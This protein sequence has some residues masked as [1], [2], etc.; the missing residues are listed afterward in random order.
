MK[1]AKLHSLSMALLTQKQYSKIKSLIVDSNN[2]LNEVFFFF[3]KLYKELSLDLYLVNTFP[4]YFLF[5]I[6][7]YDYFYQKKLDFQT[8]ILS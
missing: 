3:Y 4:N 8:Q 7:E 1:K 6:Q 2:C 5:H